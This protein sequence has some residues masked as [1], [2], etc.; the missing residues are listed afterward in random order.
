MPLNVREIAEV[1]A[2][3]REQGRAYAASA[4]AIAR[5]EE[6]IKI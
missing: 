4:T 6:S 1:A 2:P 5:K 3:D